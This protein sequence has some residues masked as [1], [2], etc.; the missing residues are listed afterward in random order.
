MSTL[1]M[2]GAEKSLISM[3]NTID[4]AFLNENGISIDILIADTTGVLYRQ[5]P[6]YIRIIHCPWLFK[7]LASPKENALKNSRSKVGTLV[8]KAFWKFSSLM[9]H[10]PLYE[11]EKYWKANKTFI[12]RLKGEYDVCLA[13][14]NGLTTYYAIDKVTA[15]K[16][17]VWVH[18][19]YNKLMCS[20]GFNKAYFEKADGIITISQKCAEN[21][22]EHF[23]QLKGKIQVIE[24]I[25]SGELVFFCLVKIVA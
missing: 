19:D 4:P 20:D 23:P 10:E 5:I 15:N 7:I 17:Y 22:V 25:S 2:G 21:I 8:L 3:L 13:Y 12:P 16:K 9:I 18:T 6:S 11:I 24:N 14:M 1:G